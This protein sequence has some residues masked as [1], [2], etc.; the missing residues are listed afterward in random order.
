VF[1]LSITTKISCS[2]ASMLSKKSFYKS[3]RN[4]DCFVTCS[5]GTL[6][7]AMTISLFL[8][9]QFHLYQSIYRFS[10]PNTCP[11]ILMAESLRT[12]KQSTFC[13]VKYQAGNYERWVQEEIQRSI[14]TKILPQFLFLLYRRSLLQLSQ[15]FQV[16]G[17]L[18]FVLC[19][20]LYVVLQVSKYLYLVYA[21]RQEKC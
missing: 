17:S 13:S 11:P 6:F 1:N 15:A 7:L 9:F 3:F 8:P 12:R 5:F 2:L 4:A 19:L 18:T 16:R 14:F 10:F 21:N 20:S